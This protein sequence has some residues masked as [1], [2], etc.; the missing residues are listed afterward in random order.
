MRR[1]NRHAVLTIVPAHKNVMLARM[2][3]AMRHL[4]IQQHL[5]CVCLWQM[6]TNA[7]TSDARRNQNCFSL[8]DLTA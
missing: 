7:G 6:A 1:V 3:Y 4:V 2:P 5:P 8:D